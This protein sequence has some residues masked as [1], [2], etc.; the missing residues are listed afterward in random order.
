MK[1][2]LILAALL[3]GTALADTDVPPAATALAGQLCQSHGGTRVYLW[4]PIGAQAW[5]LEVWCSDS[6]YY[7]VL[8]DRRPYPG[9]KP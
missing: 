8:Q 1:L 4:H 9:S 7:T 6:T 5:R 2:A 3:C